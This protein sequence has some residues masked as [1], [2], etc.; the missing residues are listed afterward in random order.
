[1][2]NLVDIIVTT[3]IEIPEEHIL[4]ITGCSASVSIVINPKERQ[5]G[6]KELPKIRLYLL[7]TKLNIY[8]LGNRILSKTNILLYYLEYR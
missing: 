4:H 6:I 2:S 5:D 1:M 3:H 7:Q 8:M